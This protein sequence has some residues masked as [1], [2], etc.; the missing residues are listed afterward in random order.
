MA[1]Q[2]PRAALEDS[3]PEASSI[4]DKQTT[5]TPA[6]VFPKAKR[7]GAFRGSPLRDAV[8]LSSEGVTRESSSHEAFTGAGQ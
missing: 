3:K 2:R 1:P 7:N 8:V 6:S 5:A 4:K